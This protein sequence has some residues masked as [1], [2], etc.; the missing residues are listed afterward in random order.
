MR[1]E[2]VQQLDD[3]DFK[4]CTG[5]QR[6]TFKQMLVIA[7]TPGATTVNPRRWTYTKVRKDLWGLEGW[8]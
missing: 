5:V 7:D 6:S 1:Y 8:E 4:R 3:E 2:I